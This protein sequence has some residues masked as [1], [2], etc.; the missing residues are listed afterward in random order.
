MSN[1]SLAI[2]MK[3]VV[4]NGKQTLI[5]VLTY[6]SFQL[7]PLQNPAVIPLRR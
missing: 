5:Y 2:T 3:K 4:G 6:R 7:H 1:A